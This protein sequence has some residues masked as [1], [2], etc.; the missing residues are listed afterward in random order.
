ME[1]AHCH[2]L[3]KSVVFV[4]S[5]VSLETD[6]F[7]EIREGWKVCKVYSLFLWG[8]GGVF[9]RMLVWAE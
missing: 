8:G 1:L 4:L 9:P 7:P 6:T 5:L 2:R 3:G